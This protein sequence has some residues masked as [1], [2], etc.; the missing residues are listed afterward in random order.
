MIKNK[1][2]LSCQSNI[3]F[4]EH[5]R[6]EVSRVRASQNWSGIIL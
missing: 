3:T 4:Y 5:V 1:T 2:E 6:L